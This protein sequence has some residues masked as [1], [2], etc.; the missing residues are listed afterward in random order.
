[1]AVALAARHRVY[2]VPKELCKDQFA[3]SELGRLYL[4]GVITSGQRE[5][6]Q[7][8]LEWHA[9][10]MRA[11]QAPDGLAVTDGGSATGDLVTGE[12]VEWATRA[13]ARW[14]VAKVWLKAIGSYGAAE[15]LRVCI[16]DRP[17]K[18]EATFINALGKLARLMGTEQKEKA[19]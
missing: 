9:S 11:L 7:R 2:G 12:Y 19:V 14:E 5:A 3:G 13:V 18:D 15:L 10:A 1:M 16:T 6:G 8:L 17:P 4:A